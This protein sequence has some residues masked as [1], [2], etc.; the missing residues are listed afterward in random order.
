MRSFKRRQGDWSFIQAVVPVILGQ[1]MLMNTLR[2]LHIYLNVFL[3][4]SWKKCFAQCMCS[5]FYFNL[6]VGLS[7]FALF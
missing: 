5:Y 7:W 3:L 2:G 6:L 4:A 1:K